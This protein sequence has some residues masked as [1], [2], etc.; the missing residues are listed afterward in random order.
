MVLG[1]R[2]DRVDGVTAPPSAIAAAIQAT[3]RDAILR[4]SGGAGAA[5]CILES[6]NES[7]SRQ[8]G[9]L[10]RLVQLAPRLIVVDLTLHGLPP[11]TYWATVRVA[12]DLSQGA[13][14]TG[15]IW[16]GDDGGNWGS[17]TVQDDGHA[18]LFLE[19][20][21]AID[22]LIGRS[23]VVSDQHAGVT[24][25][26]HNNATTLLGVI[27]RSAGV[28]DNDK[29]VCSCSGQTLWDERKVA[30]AMGQV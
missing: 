6:F 24:E 23:I 7:T 9:G 22:D 3:G 28:W 15:P 21:I 4:G 29:I 18:S 19:R 2:I 13:I 10:V 26:V 14:S 27:A 25:Y 11:G 8:V 16:Q 20:R 12:G 1:L 30:V 5:V 17:V